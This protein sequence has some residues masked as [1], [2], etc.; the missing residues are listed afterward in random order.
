MLSAGRSLRLFGPFA[1]SLALACGAQPVAVPDIDTKTSTG[2]ID[3][4]VEFEGVPLSGATIRLLGAA[5]QATTV[6]QTD[7]TFSLTEIPPGRYTLEA[8]LPGMKTVTTESRVA[9]GSTDRVVIIMSLP[10]LAEEITVP[11]VKTQGAPIAVSGLARMESAS[12]GYSPSMIFPGTFPA[13]MNTE[14]YGSIEE[15]GFRLARTAPVSTFS[16]DVDTA[17]YSN[18]RRMLNHGQS[19]PRDAVRIEELINYFDYDYPEPRNE[20]FSVTTEIGEAPWAPAHRLVQIGIQGRRIDTS[21]MPPNNLTFLLDVS[22][23]MQS[24]DKLPLLVSSLRLLVDAMRPQDR[25]A[26]VVYAGSEGLL[27]PSTS[28]E[29]KGLIL[30]RLASLEAGGSTAG[31]AGIRLAYQTARSSYQRNANNRVILATDGDFNVGVSSESELVRMIETERESGIFLSVLGFGT[32]NIKDN[33]MEAL[34]DKGNGNYAYIDSLQEARKVLVSEMG[35]TLL[36]IAKDVKIQVEFNPAKVGAYRLIGYENRML[37]NEDFNDDRKDAGE[38]GAG[39]SVTALYEIVPAGMERNVASVDPLR[40]QS[41]APTETAFGDELLQLKL[42]YKE[43]QGSRS[44]LIQRTVRDSTQS[45]YAASA[46]FRF[47]AAVAG[48]G[49]LL[50]DS[51]H[52]GTATWESVAALASSARGE[53]AEGYRAGFLDLVRQARSLGRDH[54]A[55]GNR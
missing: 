52:K 1:L 37:A 53:D 31:A 42:R 5:S 16:I 43:P 17:S 23:S 48:F 28:G 33:K 22:G 39:H 7:G 29:H 50:R 38:L 3:G 4:R 45:V 18:I 40:Y 27:L 32:G 11:A 41:T 34:A 14:E 6:S 49:M 46:N 15:S 44:Q 55:G 12:V 9:A 35:G 30:S 51:E 24:H 21:R 2:S 26:I 8:S 19:P 13:P 20:P 25:I 10:S 47:A 54:D 36:T